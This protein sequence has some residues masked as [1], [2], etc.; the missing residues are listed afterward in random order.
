M[1]EP[2]NTFDLSPEQQNTATLI[3]RLLG[4]RIADRY[5]DFCHLAAGAIPLRVSSPIAA[6]ALRELESILRQTPKI[7]ME[8]AVTPSQED[9]DRIEKAKAQL[10]ALGYNDDEVQRAREQLQRLTHK[11]EIEKIVTRLGLAADGDIARAWKSISQIHRQAHGGRA[12]HQSFV[13]DDAFRAE[14]QAPFDTVI[15]SLMIALQGRYAAFMQRIDQLVAMPDRGAAVSSFSREIPGALSLLWYFF[16]K[17]DAPE[18]LPHLT[19]RNLLAAPQS[20]KDERSGD[21]T[22]LRQWPAARYLLRMAKSSSPKARALVVDTLR[23]VSASTHPDVQE[24]GLEI[25]AALP[26]DEA[27]PLVNL[28][29]EWLTPDARFIMAQGPHDLIQNLAQGGEGDAALRATRAVFKVFSENER[30][31]TL[32]SR[33]MYE[34]HLPNAIKAIAPICMAESVALLANLLDQA[35]HISGKVQDD[36]PHDYTYYLSGQISE[37]GTKP[38]VIEAL[39]GEIV[40]ASKLVIEADPASTGDVVFRICSHSPKLFTRIALHVLSLNPAGAPGL[41]EAYLSDRNLIEATWCRVEYG[42]L[43]RAWFP[44][45]PAEIQQEILGHVDSV[46]DKYRD[47]FNKLFEQH[48]NRPPTSAEQQNHDKSIVRD[49]LW[50]WREVLPHDRKEGVEELGDPD[51]W[52]QRIYDTETTPLGAP[53]FSARP[54]HEIVTF[55]ERWRPATGEKR[56]TATALAQKLREAAWDNAAL[57]SANAPHFARLPPIYVR[58]LLEGLTNASNNRNDLDWKGALALIKAVAQTSGQ[59]SPSGMEG[60]DPDWSWT[61]KAAI[62]LVA[63]GLR[64]GAEGVPFA[65]GGLVRELI[66]E[67]YRGAP[68]QPDTENFEDSYRSVPHFGAQS[69]WRGAAIELCVLFIFWLSKEKESE[70]GKSPRQALDKLPSIRTIFETELADYTSDGRIPRAILGRYLNWL[71]YFAEPWLV[72]HM[73]A[74]FPE[75]NLSLRD[76]AWLSHLSVDSGPNSDLAPRMR[77]CYVTEIG[78]LGTDPSGGDRQHVDDRLSQYLIILY[79]EAALPDDVFEQFWNTAPVGSLQHAMWFLGVQLGQIPNN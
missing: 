60:D 78:R 45:L 13:V 63:S 51:V 54:I 35:V 72:R 24:M 39:V 66:L 22:F 27:A 75:E 21:G 3:E 5:I 73:D 8:V 38:G 56:E 44:S 55:L 59:P 9:N 50:H 79:I 71:S 76:A 46:P 34:H 7:P 15:R 61:R 29:E 41:A 25:L 32:H 19:K 11:E 65:D 69:T 77:D 68:R 10:Q 14:W 52:R 64:R 30:L 62:E 20:Q 4:K 57:Y 53:D 42:Q 43:A 33:H 40:R 23:N 31:A 58:R 48:E 12:L 1:D 37:H 49:L 67:L 74:L 47:R 6:H 2:I 16:N 36:P 26:P 18:W 70:V 17:L 28:A